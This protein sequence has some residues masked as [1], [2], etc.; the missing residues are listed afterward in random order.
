MKIISNKFI[1]FGDFGA[2]NFLG[3]VFTKQPKEEVT[4]RTKRHEQ[5]HTLQQYE[6]IAV[7]AIV[8]LVLCNV[9]ASWWYLL[10]I[11]LIPFIFYIFGFLIEMFLPPYHNAQALFNDKETP[12]FK[13]LVRWFTNIWMHAYNDNCFEREAYRNDK[14]VNYLVTRKPFGWVS[15]I[16]PKEERNFRLFKDLKD[17]K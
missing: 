7:S 14:V 8:S 4:L 2:I 10:G 16:I 1:P 15:Y 12:F 5:V 11:I 3:F 17:I 13:R 9:F 6:L